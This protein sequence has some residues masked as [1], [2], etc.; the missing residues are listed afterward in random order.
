MDFWVR[1][2]EWVMQMARA[3]GA[4]KTTL[5]AFWDGCEEGVGPI[6]TAQVVRLARDA[7]NVRIE[8]ID[9]TQLLT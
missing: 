7:G 2:N 8:S 3:W 6:G 4:D 5:V 1:G 9:S